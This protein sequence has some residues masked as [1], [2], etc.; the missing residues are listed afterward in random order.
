M[1]RRGYSPR[2]PGPTAFGNPTALEVDRVLPMPGRGFQSACVSPPTHG[3]VALGA[4]PATCSAHHTTAIPWEAGLSS[5]EA[6]LCKAPGETGACE[7]GR[8]EF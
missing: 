4:P 2:G 5:S 8:G 1:T 6:Q 3:Q 7:K